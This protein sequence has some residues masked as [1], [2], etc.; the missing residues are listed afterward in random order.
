MNILK[1]E[2]YG[3]MKKSDDNDEVKKLEEE[4][5]NGNKFNE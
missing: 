1:N 5:I 3:V 2:I 4:I